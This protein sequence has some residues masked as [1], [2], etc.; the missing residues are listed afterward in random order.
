MT[1]PQVARFDDL[2]PRTAYAIWRLR[3]TVFVVEQECPYLELDGRDLEPSTRHIWLGDD[4]PTA[5]L[6]ILDDG[7][8][9][10]IGR[11]VVAQAHRG[12]GLADRLMEAALAEVGDSPSVLDA[13][14]H[15][16]RWYERF[17]YR[18]CGED[19][20]EDGIAHTPM[21]RTA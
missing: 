7:D 13:Q 19:F 6:R 5:Y 11:V 4:E 15:L 8:H 10:R 12:Q 16:E 2:D 21:S 3:E 20:V 18:R 1:D 17:G 9:L 14:S